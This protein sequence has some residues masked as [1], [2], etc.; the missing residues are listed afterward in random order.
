VEEALALL[1][2]TR[3]ARPRAGRTD[4]GRSLQRARKRR[5][6]LTALPDDPGV[7]LV[8]NDAGQVLYVGKSVSLRTRAAA[9]FAPSSPDTDWVAQAE[10][11]DHRVTNSELGALLLES[12][13]IRSLRPPGNAREK[14]V[15]PSVYLR[16]RLDIPFPILEVAPEPAPGHAVNVGPLI[17]RHA[18]VELLEQ[19]TSLFGLRHCGRRLPRRPWPS[20]YGQ[21]GRCLSPCLGDLDPNAY[22]RRIDAAL[23]LFSGPRDGRAALL[24]D[25]DRRIRAEAACQRYERAAWLR[26]RRDRLAVLLDRL[27]GVLA[28]THARPRLILAEHPRGGRFDAFWLVA[29]RVVDWGP[30][31]GVDDVALRTASALRAGDGTGFATHLTPDEAADHHVVATWLAANETPGLDLTGGADRAELERFLARAGLM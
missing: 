18:A 6:D 10:H 9:H 29:G 26:R 13:M 11:V 5:P 24:A 23:E 19:V 17:G 12:R 25:V 22:R 1:R 7:Y 28:A 8:R 20:A 4:G 16:C 14:R 30:P 2:P 31:A 3:P 21:M 27:G 15:D